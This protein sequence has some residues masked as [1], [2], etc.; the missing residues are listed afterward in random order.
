MKN[1]LILNL[2]LMALGLSAL[3][4]QG[5]PLQH[6]VMNIKI[7]LPT[8]LP[9]DGPGGVT[10]KA[11]PR[12]PDDMD[13]M[14]K[15]SICGHPGDPAVPKHV[16]RLILPPGEIKSLE[17]T[18]KDRKTTRSNIATLAPIPSWVHPETG[19]KISREDGIDLQDGRNM[20]AYDSFFPESVLGV[21]A[22]ENFRG[23]NILELPIS[24]G[25]YQAADGTWEALHECE[26][27]ID[28]YTDLSHLDDHPVIGGADEIYALMEV[29]SLQ[30][31][32]DV[33]EGYLEHWREI[34]GYDYLIITTK[35]IDNESSMNGLD[36]FLTHKRALGFNPYVMTIAAIESTYSSGSRTEKMK[37]YISDF[38]KQYGCE[39]VLL[40]GNPDC[41]ADYPNSLDSHRPA[42]MKLCQTDAD[43]LGDDDTGKAMADTYF[44]DIGDNRTWDND[45]DGKFAE[46]WRAIGLLDLNVGRIA[47]VGGYVDTVI[48]MDKNND[49]DHV[50]QVISESRADKL[51]NVFQRIMLYDRELDQSWRYNELVGGSYPFGTSAPSTAEGLTET[52]RRIHAIDSQYTAYTIFQNGNDY[53]LD[54]QWFDG[55]AHPEADAELVGGRPSSF[56]SFWHTDEFGFGLVYWFAHGGYRR[57]T[58]GGGTTADGSMLTQ[59]EVY[60]SSGDFTPYPAV[61]FSAA[62][63]NMLTGTLSYQNGSYGKQRAHWANLA[64]ALQH[65]A[66]IAVAAFTGF[67]YAPDFDTNQLGDDYLV[68]ANAWYQRE[69]YCNLASGM[70][71]GEAFRKAKD[72]AQS[73]FGSDRDY[74]IELVNFLRLNFLGDPSQYLFQDLAYLADDLYESG[75]GNDSIDRATCIYSGSGVGTDGIVDETITVDNLVSKDVDYYELNSLNCMWAY[76]DIRVNTE[77]C[78]SMPSDLAVKLYDASYREIPSTNI[79]YSEGVLYY[80]PSRFISDTVYVAIEPGRYVT[81]YEMVITLSGKADGN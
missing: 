22:I 61:V 11:M 41:R 45:G 60:S 47:P 42:P 55:V 14:I 43:A 51:W 31:W 24:A 65:N 73:Y 72:D 15:F 16:Y 4:A 8:F 53:G 23:W 70:N 10:L 63:N 56:S 76:L 26:L 20:Q 19:R 33:W 21:A 78:G 81:D 57:I 5:S 52:G 2:L 35:A 37:A 59:E 39:Y 28:V 48:E 40:V 27:E 69:F 46:G 64:A 50:D 67:S 7:Q 71:F 44:A 12:N 58:V 29:Y 38:W 66:A 30:N 17:V 68:G 62:C 36:E 75:S 32:T 18:I 77:A 1:M 79:N 13:S 34:S 25:R 6:Q 54:D 74:K 49:G 80:T 3:A 9:V